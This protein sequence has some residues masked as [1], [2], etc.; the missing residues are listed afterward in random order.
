[1]RLQSG[2]LLFVATACMLFSLMCQNITI[3][4]GNYGQVL[5]AGIVGMTAADIC[6]VIVFIRGGA[7][8]WGALII[9]LPSLFIV[10]DFLRR[11]PHLW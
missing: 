8:K 4:G 5:L 9:A 6:C 1:M 11:V 10:W 7:L 2:L 3:A